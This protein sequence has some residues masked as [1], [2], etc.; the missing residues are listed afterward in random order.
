M[1]AAHER[2]AEPKA[3]PR[4]GRGSALLRWG[5]WALAIAG[6][7]AL[8][9]LVLRARLGAPTAVL[10]ATGV[11]LLF[12]LWWIGR[13]FF[14]LASDPPSPRSTEVTGA[15]R[16]E[17]EREK[18]ALLIA[19]KELEFDHALGKLTAS[20]FAALSGRYR[21]RAVA[22]LRQLDEGPRSYR[23]AILGELRRR[24]ALAAKSPAA[25][26]D[27]AREASGLRCPSCGAPNDADADY[28][29]KCGSRLANG[30]VA[31]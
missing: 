17:L 20:D 2:P 10:F 9:L 25:A 8:L 23:D 11:A 6:W 19:I 1:S 24:V 18:R 31:P 12:A 28:C 13:T 5:S 16:R 14:A 27:A 30:E 21:A 15:R 29:K 22:V 3:A 7:A 26:A 4:I